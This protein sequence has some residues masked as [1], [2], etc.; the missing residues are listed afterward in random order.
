MNMDDFPIF[1]ELDYGK[2]LTGKP[3]IW[4]ENNSGFRLR[5]SRENQSIES[6]PSH[7]PSGNLT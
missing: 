3:Y 2:I 6:S 7:I 4:W 5:F 1:I